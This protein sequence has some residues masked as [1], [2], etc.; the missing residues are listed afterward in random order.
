MDD[1]FLTSGD[2]EGQAVVPV[3][4]VNGAYRELLRTH[5]ARCDPHVCQY[6][7]SAC[8]STSHFL[9]G[10]NGGLVS[11]CVASYW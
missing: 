6:R 3:N 9:S 5:S 4:L 8:K 7:C 1:K 10:R 2:T 11:G